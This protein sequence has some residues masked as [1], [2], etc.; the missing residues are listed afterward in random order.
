MNSAMGKWI[1]TTC[2]ACLANNAALMSNGFKFA[3]LLL[4]HDLPGHLR[5]DRAKVRIRAGFRERER[6]FLVGIKHLG[7]EH[8]VRA[9]DG[10]RNVVAVSPRDRR[11]DRDAQSCWAKTEV[12]DFYVCAGCGFFLRARGKA[13]LPRHESARPHDC[14][15]H[16][17]CDE[18]TSPHAFS[19]FHSVLR[20]EIPCLSAASLLDHP[21][22]E[23]TTASACWPRT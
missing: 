6:E 13:L 17:T 5:M 9:H 12:V 20:I 7:L 21:K 15:C 11:P 3:P 23:S 19:P 18:H 16:Q 14:C 4:H 2:C 10:M 1:S 8:F 22:V